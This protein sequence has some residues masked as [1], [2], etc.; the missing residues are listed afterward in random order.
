MSTPYPFTALVGQDDLRLGLLLNAVSPAVGGV[1]VRGEKGTAKSTAVRALAAL[2][3]EV[4]VVAGCRFSCDPGAPD[5]ACPDGPHEAGTGVSRAARTVELPV[6]ASEDRLVGALDIERA[7]SEG[8]KAFEPGLLADAH[9][10]ILYVDEVNL[11]HDHLV[12]LLLDAA[13]MGAS[14]V[15]REGVSVRHAARFLLV[16]TMNPEE[17]ELRPQLLDRFGLTVEVAASRETDLRVEVVRRRLAYDDDPAGF[18][19]RWA[20]EEAALRERIVSARALLPR[21]VLGDGVLR[22]IAATC[23]AFEVDGMRAD[24]VMARTATALAAWAGREEVVSDDVRQAALLALPHRRRRNPFDAPGLDEDK[25]DEALQDAA[26]EQGDDDP[27]PDG[28]GGGVPRR[29]AGPRAT[30]AARTRAAPTTEVRTTGAPTRPA[31]RTPG[32]GTRPRRAAAVSSNP[33]GPVSRSG[34]RC[35]ACRVWA[36]ARRGG[37]PGRVPSTAVP[38]VRGGPRAR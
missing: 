19:A 24:I 31:G 6:G 5:P 3:P 26:D 9:R 15:E 27:D 30:A 37:V 36:R 25:L 38:P 23:A 12:D 11:L 13:A 14:Y 35:S 17:G 32:A 34:R 21:V 10:G 20:D 8:V 18:A 16:G 28:P 29:A 2:M 4:A 1:L 33:C 7:L 22:Q